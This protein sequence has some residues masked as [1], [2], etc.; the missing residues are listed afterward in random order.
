MRL[1]LLDAV[2]AFRNGVV[3]YNA[4]EGIGGEVYGEVAAKSKCA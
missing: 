3:K 2:S 4:L 1:L